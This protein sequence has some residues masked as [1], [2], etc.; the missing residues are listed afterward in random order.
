MTPD[1]FSEKLVSAYQRARQP[2]YPN[3]KL[4]RGESRSVSSEIEDLLACYLAENLPLIDGI[5]INQPMSIVIDGK[6]KTIKPDLAVI[7]NDS[8]RA[9]VDL[10]MDLGYKRR[11]DEIKT[12]FN[13][14][15]CLI[16]AMRDQ[17]AS[18]W[19]RELAANYRQTVHVSHDVAYIFLV[20]SDQNISA[21]AYLNVIAAAN[22]I[23]PHGASLH[24]LVSR[25]HPNDPHRNV[26]DI[27]R[28]CQQQM[29][30]TLPAFMNAIANCL[31]SRD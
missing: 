3:G 30:T 13:K 22:A 7:K 27:L 25:V 9:L 23:N 4:H 24:T 18:Y 31:Q 5:R 10:K 29:R 21:E 6:R 12:M 17:Q 16:E 28:N 14:A 8:I 1:E 26:G 15:S 2:L 11:P 20:V 19:N